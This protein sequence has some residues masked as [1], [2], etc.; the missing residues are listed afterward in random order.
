MGA[1]CGAHIRSHAY[2][3]EPAGKLAMLPSKSGGK[4]WLIEE[5]EQ[6]IALAAQYKCG[7]WYDI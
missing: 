7:A 6:L 5:D 2:K 3:V 1:E 4:Q